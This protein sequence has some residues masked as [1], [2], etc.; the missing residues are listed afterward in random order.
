MPALKDNAIPALPKFYDTVAE[1]SRAASFPMPS[2]LQTGALLRTLAGL[3][4]AGYFLEL[5]TGTGLGVCWLLEGMDSSSQLTTVESEAKWLKIAQDNITDSRV[6]FVHSEGL[7]FLQGVPSNSYDLIF[8][9]TWPGKYIGFEHS[10]RIL[11]KGGL[12]VLDDMLPQPNW[13][14]DHPPK[15]ENLIKAIDALP[16]DQFRSVKMCWYTGH[17]LISKR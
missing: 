11:A 9:D 15:V 14:A 1:A 4:P 17:I 12:I 10:L 2:D 7:R 5:G 13:P 3:K 8:A 6:K 16:Q